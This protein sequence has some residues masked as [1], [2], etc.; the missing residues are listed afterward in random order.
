[1]APEKKRSTL[2]LAVMK[3]AENT[4]FTRCLQRTDIPLSRQHIVL[5]GGHT[6]ELLASDVFP[7]SDFILIPGLTTTDIQNGLYDRI[8]KKTLEEKEREPIIAGYIAFQDLLNRNL[9][10]NDPLIQYSFLEAIKQELG[11]WK[12]PEALLYT[13]ENAVDLEKATYSAKQH[14]LTAKAVEQ[15]L[16]EARSQLPQILQLGF[17]QYAQIFTQNIA[18]TMPKV[19]IDTL[20]Q[21]LPKFESEYV[22]PLESILEVLNSLLG[23]AV[24][25]KRDIDVFLERADIPSIE[26]WTIDHLKQYLEFLQ[27]HIL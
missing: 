27:Q 13:L 23:L 6:A 1:M 21:D 19:N 4:F 20:L 2:E 12:T 24:K 22:S 8:D 17:A 26:D 18:Q 14:L 15:F 16:Q 5:G 3:I 10:R 11:Q 9:F 25:E 7:F